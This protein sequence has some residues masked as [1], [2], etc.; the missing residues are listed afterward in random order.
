MSTYRHFYPEVLSAEDLTMLHRTVHDLVESG[1]ELHR[2]R[3][4]EHMARIV[5]RLYRIGL[6][7]PA[8]LSGLAAMMADREAGIRR[9]A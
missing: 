6:T 9:S 1:R 8:K 7:E 3:D 2:E 5:L 4:P